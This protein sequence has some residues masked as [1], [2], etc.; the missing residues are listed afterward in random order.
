MK[1]TPRL[2][3]IANHIPKNTICG[4]I[5]TD[6]AYIPIYIVEN[7][8][9][10][11]VIATDI[12]KGP[13]DIAN[14]QIRLAALQ[15]KIE[16]R[17]GNGLEAIHPYEVETLVIAGMGGLLIKDILENSKTVTK[18]IKRFIL[19]PMIAQRELREYLIDNNF[20]IINEDLVQE[21]QKIYE[22]IIA[23][24]GKQETKKD[25][26]LDI[27][28]PLIRNRH[29]LLPSLIHLKKEELMKII[30]KCQGKN[31]TNAEERIREC[32]KKIKDLEEVG[33]CL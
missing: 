6:H 19:Q 18:S 31:S 32:S 15:D 27:G 24:H 25:I 26:Y 30:I 5:G 14:K 2:Q 12:N 7:K 22:I 11:R 13:L 29:P 9:S 33:K 3:T 8:I 21:K 4:D 16:T 17:L 23:I 1:L 20:K 28:E 10:G